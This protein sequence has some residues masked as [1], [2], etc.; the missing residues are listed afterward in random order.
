MNK[1]VKIII[2]LVVVLG[3]FYGGVTY[4]QSIATKS[5]TA[6]TYS[7]TRTVRTGST[8]GSVGGSFGGGAGGSATI[9]TVVSENATSIT[10]ALKSGSVVVFYSTSTPIM[11]TTSGTPADITAGANITVIGTTNS[12][13]SVTAN[14]IQIR[15]ATTQ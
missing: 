6:S 12:D 9:G 5:T 13:G 4:G 15:P 3:L 14:S 8:T 7:G 10:L 1:A 2:G 11:K